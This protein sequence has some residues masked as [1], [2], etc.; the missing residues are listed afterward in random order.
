MPLAVSPTVYDPIRLAPGDRISPKTG[1]ELIGISRSDMYRL[2]RAL[3]SYVDP[4]SGEVRELP[5]EYHALPDQRARNAWRRQHTVVIPEWGAESLAH[6]DW[7]I[8]RVHLQAWLP[9]HR[10]SIPALL[11]S[12]ARGR[13][14]TQGD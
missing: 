8:S 9:A 13:F 2:I 14:T 11:S 10:H 1:A 12:A 3:E 6:G 5:D 4:G 7:R